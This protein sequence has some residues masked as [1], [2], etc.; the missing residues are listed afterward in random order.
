MR[1]VESDPTMSATRGDT[2]E[3]S[4]REPQRSLPADARLLLACAARGPD[5]GAIEPALGVD[6]AWSGLVER[7]VRHRLGP[8]VYATLRAA[9]EAGAVRPPDA[10]LGRLRAIYDRHALRAARRIAKLAE[11]GA[12]L[13]RAGIPFIV[14]KGAALGPALFGDPA[15]RTM[16]DVDLL[17][18]RDQQ[19]AAGRVLQAQGYVA[20]VSWGSEAWY[21]TLHHHSAPLSSPDGFLIVELHYTIAEQGD[22]RVPVEELWVRSRRQV[23]G[24]V[25]FSVLA[26]EDLLL[27]LCLHLAGN[28]RVAD[29]L[30]RD[31]RDVAQLIRHESTALDWGAVVERAR[32][33]RMAGYAYWTLWLAHEMVGADAPP[34]VLDRLVEGRRPGRSTRLLRRLLPELLLAS[35]PW[36]FRLPPWVMAG[37][38]PLLLH[39]DEPARIGILAHRAARAGRT[40]LDHA[41]RSWWVARVARRLAGRREPP[42]SPDLQLG[43]GV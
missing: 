36:P 26:A 19:E 31:L 13:E 18:R 22:V 39:T 7:A 5:L 33:W 40:A 43:T 4:R 23:I 2:A 14:L 24:D 32:A 35:T 15:L 38:V 28:N 30:L 27:H 20:D 12:V 3:P 9:S 11:I 17:V 6:A 16:G 37:T 10:L 29:G 21:R 42:P 8:L 34:A 41:R 25:P 1:G